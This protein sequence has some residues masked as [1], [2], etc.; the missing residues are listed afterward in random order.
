V[1]AADDRVAEALANERARVAAE[2]RD[3]VVQELTGLSL[4][5]ASLVR[6]AGGASGIPV[7][8][9]A[10]ADRQLQTQLRTLRLL[11][12]TLGDDPSESMTFARTVDRLARRV[13][14]IWSLAVTVDVPPD[15]VVE[16]PLADLVRR[17]VRDALVNAVRY[18]S[19]T[20]ADVRMALQEEHLVVTVRQN[21]SGYP[22]EGTLEHDDLMASRRGP[23]ALKQQVQLLG[24]RMR[25]SSRVQGATT[26][27]AVPLGAPA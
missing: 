7:S 24:G 9:I 16:E 20:S 4:S 2:L 19:V 15:L 18:G 14:A 5:L 21:G 26:E 6:G 8:A 23:V 22:F 11:L 1:D 27:F 3:G 10:D 12:L 17:M 25:I 13:A